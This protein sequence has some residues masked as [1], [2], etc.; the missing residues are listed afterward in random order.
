MI[1]PLIILF[2]WGAALILGVV[3]VVTRRKNLLIAGM[4][5]A[6]AGLGVTYWLKSML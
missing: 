2:L 4:V 1:T 5:A 3:G 6:L